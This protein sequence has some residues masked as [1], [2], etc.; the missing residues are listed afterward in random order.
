MNSL[1][2]EFWRFPAPV[3]L[4]L[5]LDCLLYWFIVIYFPPDT[6]F[7]LAQPQGTELRCALEYTLSSIAENRGSYKI[8]C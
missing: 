1:R 7:L 5:E 6:F 8:I 3:F 2:P 4:R